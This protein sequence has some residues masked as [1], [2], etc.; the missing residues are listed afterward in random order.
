MIIPN[1]EVQ[2][3]DADSCIVR[4]NRYINVAARSNGSTL[5]QQR[6]SRQ[7]TMLIENWVYPSSITKK[8]VKQ[9]GQNFIEKSLFFAISKTI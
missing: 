5:D 8:T 1:V 6:D 7:S 9:S 3:V 4:N 2:R